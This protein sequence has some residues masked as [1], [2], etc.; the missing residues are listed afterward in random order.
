MPRGSAHRGIITV[1]VTHHQHALKR[2]SYSESKNR[3]SRDCQ[4]ST[5]T[6]HPGEREVEGK[7]GTRYAARS[8]W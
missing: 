7:T 3:V 4:S 2:S 6:L 1:L 8:Q 5:V